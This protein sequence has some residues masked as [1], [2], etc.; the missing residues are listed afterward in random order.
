M[1]RVAAITDGVGEGSGRAP[2]ASVMALP[3]P[4]WLYHHL[5]VS[6]DPAA[7]AALR[8]AA[9]GPGVIPWT[10]SAG[11]AAEDWFYLLATPPAAQ[12]PDHMLGTSHRGMVATQPV[13]RP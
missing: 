4:D 7:V 1:T 10:G 13:H 9:A 8:T 11:S 5:R 12:R 3:H 2:D 6:G